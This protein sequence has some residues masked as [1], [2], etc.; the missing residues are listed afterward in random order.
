MTTWNP[1][2]EPYNYVVVGG[3]RT[4]GIAS[5]SGLGSPRK[6][7][8]RQGYGFSGATVVYKG[9][10][11][12][13][14]KLSIALYSARDW[15][16]WDSFFDAVLKKPPPVTS[17]TSLYPPRPRAL[18][19]W[20]PLLERLDIRAAVVVNPHAPEQR[21]PGEWVAEI[22][23]LEFRRPRLA[24]SRPDGAQS[25]PLDPVEQQIAANTRIIQ[26]LASQ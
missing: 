21:Q 13:P 10:W 15:E 11:L 8:Q 2:D 6:W 16:G 18:D 4:P 23:M 1:L 12:S 7:D 25:R 3:R 9:T 24:L 26:E 17:P 14:F 20:H 22:E 19:V 5:L